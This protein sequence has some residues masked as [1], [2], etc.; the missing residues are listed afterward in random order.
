MKFA[1]K[2]LV[3]KGEIHPPGQDDPIGRWMATKKGIERALKEVG[4]KPTYV[5]VSSMVE[6]EEGLESKTQK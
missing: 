4:W 5:E 1:R 3:E 2:H 6:A